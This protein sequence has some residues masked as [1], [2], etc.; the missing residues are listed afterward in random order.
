MSHDFAGRVALGVSLAGT[1]LLLV[2]VPSR[3][4]AFQ[5][6]AA[7]AAPATRDQT[8]GRASYVLGAGDEILVRA[9]DVPEFSDKPQRVDP[10]GDIR[11]PIVGRIH[12]AG[13]TQEQLEAAIRDRLKT[14]LNEPDVTV[15]VIDARSQ[16]VSVLGAVAQPGVRALGGNGT[17]IELLS[18]AGGPTADAG[19]V[20]RITRKLDQGPI[21]LP[22]AANHPATGYSIAE[23]PLKALMDATSPEKNIQI[24]P[25]DVIS[26]PR[27]EVVY[28]VGEVGKVGA[29]PLLV[30]KSMTVVE[31]L[32][33]SGGALRTAAPKNA[34]ILRVAAGGQMRTEI[35]VDL[36]KVMQGRSEDVALYAGDILVV[37]D[38]KGKRATAALLQAAIQVGVMISTYGIIY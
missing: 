23:V 26:I 24:R 5:T 32:S 7:A 11:L 30:G 9:V 4:H 22:G 20:V 35:P 34:R 13:L 21:P 14:Y 12:A 29:V 2:G 28:V 8:G 6:P 33:A 3:A 18:A 25:D 17:L 10:S 16:S 15:T 38:S 37:P 27:A 1:V 36:S 31:A 19:P